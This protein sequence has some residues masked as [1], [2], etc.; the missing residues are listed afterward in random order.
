MAISY[1]TQQVGDV[2]VFYRE[3]GSKDAPVLLLLH[4]FPSSSHMFRDLIPLLADR[5]RVI[6]PDLP[7]FGRTSSPARG[8]FPYTFDKLAAVMTAFTEALGLSRYALYVFDYG[9]PV[10]FRMSAANPDRIS[11][12]IS[13]N[14]N[15]TS[16]GSVMNGRRGTHIGVTP[17]LKTETHVVHLYLLR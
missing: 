13:Q 7:G 6:A 16:K 17:P 1:K 15:A 4:G 5:Y 3:A 14:G 12:I 9:A 8:E 11:A 10:G 2:E